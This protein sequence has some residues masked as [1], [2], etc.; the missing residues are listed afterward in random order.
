MS[1]RRLNQSLIFK[2]FTSNPARETALP[3]DFN[4]LSNSIS[5]YISPYSISSALGSASSTATPDRKRVRFEAQSVPRELLG[6]I[7][8]LPKPKKLKLTECSRVQEALQRALDFL[9]DEFDLRQEASD[10]FPPEITSS[11]IRSSTKR[12]ESAMLAASA[13]SVCCSCCGFVLTSSIYKIDN[14]DNLIAPLRDVLDD[15]GRRGDIWDVCALCHTALNRGTIPKFSAK[16]AINVTLCQNYP[17]TLRGL[18]PVEECLI[19]KCH[20]IGT[21]LKLRPGNR[22]SPANYKALRGHM[23]LT[24]QDPSPLLQILP[25]PGLRL[26]NI[27]RFSGL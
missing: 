19:A 8:L 14:G 18:T 25:H 26:D 15:C 7:P 16:N 3:L 20:P 24:P 17:S 22:P 9:S 5:V 4:P 2:S 10:I 23:I 13:R 12:Y 1:A 11:S 6:T 27:I 21:I